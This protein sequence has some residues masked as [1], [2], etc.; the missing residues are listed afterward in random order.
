MPAVRKITD[1]RHIT[2]IH[3]SVT[4]RFQPAKSNAL[5]RRRTS[6]SLQCR[7]SSRPAK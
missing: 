6:A 3:E 7:Y 1:T 5:A 2:I 4:L